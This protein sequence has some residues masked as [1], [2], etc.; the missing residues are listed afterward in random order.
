MPLS[1]TQRNGAFKWTVIL[2]LLSAVCY[3]I[4]SSQYSRQPSITISFPVNKDFYFD[5]A[6]NSMQK[7]P[8]VKSSQDVSFVDSISCSMP[9]SASLAE[10]N[11][12]TLKRLILAWTPLHSRKPLWGIK[13]WSFSNC[14]YT[15]CEV[16]SNRSQLDDA[17]LL[18]FRIRSLKADKTSKPYRPYVEHLD[19]S[20]MPPYRKRGQIWMDINQ[21]SYLVE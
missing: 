11:N 20:D 9:S 6:S 7:A 19:L 17:D 3:C 16:T 12:K 14:S 1:H 10:S 4:F 5:E 2:L 8:T 18:L 13:P 15:N 21:A